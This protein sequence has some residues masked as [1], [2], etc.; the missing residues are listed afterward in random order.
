VVTGA[1]SGIGE[2]TALAFAAAGARV[3]AADVNKI[4]ADAT[5][6]RIRTEGGG[7]MAVACD[8]ADEAAVH[9]LVDETVRTYGR[10]DFAHNNAGIDGDMSSR[11]ADLSPGDW[12]RVLAVN[13]TGV[14][15]CM[16]YEIPAMLANGSGAVVNTASIAGLR[17]FGKSAAYG[18]S[19]H[20]VV[21]LTRVAAL[22]YASAGVRVNAVCPGVIE[23]A[24]LEEARASNPRMVEGIAA[25]TPMKRL[26]Q[27]VEIAELVVWLCSDEASFLTGQAIAVDGGVTAS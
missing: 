22:D 6:E 2:A 4:G 21:G 10:L 24:M 12:G 23:T 17:G 25:A 8:V 19:K 26:G 18:A 3:V 14:F 20:G 9:A 27:P 5:A 15:L 13:L 16:K 7:A 11:V 1:G